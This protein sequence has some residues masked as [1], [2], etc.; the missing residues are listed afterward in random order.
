[1][2]SSTINTLLH[3]LPQYRNRLWII[4][5]QKDQEYN[6]DWEWPEQL[7][8]PNLYDIPPPEANDQ[9]NPKQRPR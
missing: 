2:F 3:G 8:K 9:I 4:A 5:F 7:A 1:M 6:N